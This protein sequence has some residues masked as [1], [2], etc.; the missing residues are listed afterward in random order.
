M[1]S[2]SESLSL[3]LSLSLYFIIY[4]VRTLLAS[5][6]YI[7]VLLSFVVLKEDGYPK[8]MEYSIVPVN[9]CESKRGFEERFHSLFQS[10]AVSSRE[11]KRIFC[12]RVMST[13]AVYYEY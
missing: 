4:N 11:T 13:T 5:T 8:P 3:D 1:T 10:I 7:A 2:F 9:R 12:G 6:V